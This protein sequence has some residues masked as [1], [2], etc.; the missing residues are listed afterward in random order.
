MPGT[1]MNTDDAGDV[2]DSVRNSA[3]ST[4]RRRGRT[5]GSGNGNLCGSS[6][7][8]WSPPSQS[9]SRPDRP[10]KEQAVRIGRIAFERLAF[11]E[12]V[13]TVKSVRGAEIFPRA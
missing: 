6:F 13:P 5:D 10:R 2:A 9:P 8:P 4:P 7:K 3:P 12:A 11:D 1:M